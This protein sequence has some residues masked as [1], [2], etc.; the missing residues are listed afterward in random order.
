VIVLRFRIY[1]NFII[2]L[3]L[4]LRQTHA[5]RYDTRLRIWRQISGTTFWSVCHW[6]KTG[7]GQMS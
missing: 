6:L 1:I 4:K 2:L 5:R 3:P 7:P